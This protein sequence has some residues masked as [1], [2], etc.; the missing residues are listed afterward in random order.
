LHVRPHHPHGGQLDCE[1]E[2][3][4]ITTAI[5]CQLERSFVKQAPAGKVIIG[6]YA[7]E[8][9]E[10]R[11]LI[12]RKEVDWHSP[13]QTDHPLGPQIGQTSTAQPQSTVLTPNPVPILP[14]PHHQRLVDLSLTQATRGKGVTPLAN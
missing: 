7:D 3:A 10:R 5:C 6:R 13:M 2:T 4:H 12:I 9:A 8:P 14:E 11:N 1:P